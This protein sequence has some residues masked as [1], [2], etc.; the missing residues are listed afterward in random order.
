MAGLLPGAA[1]AHDE[2]GEHAERAEQ[3]D[4][5]GGHRDHEDEVQ[6]GRGDG[7]GRPAE[8]GSRPGQC[9]A[10][11]CDGRQR[12]RGEQ[13]LH[14]RPPA[15]GRQPAI[16]GKQQQDRDERQRRPPHPLAQPGGERQRGPAHRQR[17]DRGSG[18][19]EHH[20]SAER[21]AR[22]PAQDEHAQRGE[23]ECEGER[24]ADRALRRVRPAEQRPGRT[25]RDQPDRD[26]AQQRYRQL[27]H[28][29]VQG[30]S[31]SS[32]GGRDRHLSRA[33]AHP[34]VACHRL[35]S[36]LP[37]SGSVGSGSDP[38]SASS[39]SSISLSSPSTRGARTHGG[40]SGS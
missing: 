21:M 24:E 19:G 10:G 32:V 4:P 9:R 6:P 12:R 35:C 37:G 16:R 11:Q 27:D 23:G 26:P 29:L 25:E 38:S 20:Q 18:P 28:A 1:P 31:R 13:D 2:R 15:G 40:G 30:A 7:A 5:Q 8:Q 17:G 39:A 14:Q 3:H 34:K 33:G 22:Q 36:G